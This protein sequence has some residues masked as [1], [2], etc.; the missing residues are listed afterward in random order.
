MVTAAHKGALRLAAV[1]ERAA[2]EGLGIGM[3]LADARARIPEL[4]V[5]E[6]DDAAD[7]R[8]LLHLLDACRRFTPA[9][10]LHAP[11]GLDLDVTGCAALFGGER[12]LLQAALARMRGLGLKTCGA[13]ADTAA[14]AYAAARFG[15][16]G[17]VETGV[18][19]AA[20]APLPVEALRLE[21]QGCAVLRGLGFRTIGQLLD[22]PR[23]ALA[24][25][26]GEDAVARLD[27]ALGRRAAP[28]ELSLEQPPF[29]AERRLFEPISEADQVLQVARDLAQ[30]LCIALD[31][32]GVGGRRFALELFR[33]D[34][35]VRRLEVCA[36]RPLRHPAGIVSLFTERLAGLDEGL[37]ADFGFDQVRLV[38]AGTAPL[39]ATAGD[40]LKETPGAGAVEALADRIAA[41]A[42]LRTTR[43]ASLDVHTPEDAV[44]PRD[45]APSDLAPSDLAPSD[46]AMPTAWS[47]AP[48]RFLGAPLRP[49]RLL[50]PPQ[51]I[52]VPLAGVP[53]GPPARFTW[54]RLSRT[55]VRAEGPE[56][57]EPEWAR[58]TPHPDAS[59]APRDYYRLE[60]DQ[61]RRYWVFRQGCYTP[62]AAPSPACPDRI[63]EEIKPVRPPPKPK[64][65]LDGLGLQEARNARIQ[66]TTR[67]R[68]PLRLVDASADPS[69]Q[70]E[71]V[72]ATQDQGAD[73]RPPPPVW[74]L[75][76]LFG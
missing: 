34:G 68:A 76:G 50:S 39:A 47:A 21:P 26:L 27:E 60:D 73:P 32:G 66:D 61:G 17:V 30:D 2:R 71:P 14:L 8:Q 19:A 29:R 51:P 43:L 59:G 46:L 15:G 74:F 5:T 53:E 22:L 36:S 10:A 54:R 63:S 42:G 20:L 18:R 75:H 41:R 24:R 35:A 40:L 55:V 48:P 16:G 57:L 67:P 4:A 37:Q 62:P 33:V 70:T 65:T 12:R 45:L 13:M 44:A 7:L 64:A 72:Q 25:R 69:Y 49:I 58:P 1:D 38:A 23:A 9:L 56:R 11:D 52:E 31:G 6:A 28:L 3:T